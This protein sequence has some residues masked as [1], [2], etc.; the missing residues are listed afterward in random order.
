MEI[1]CKATAHIAF[2]A[3]VIAD[4]MVL[5]RRKDVWIGKASLSV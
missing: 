4:N 5:C 1:G 3:E 2:I